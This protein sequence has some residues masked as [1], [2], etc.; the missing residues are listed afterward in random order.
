MTAKNLA[1][2]FGPTLMR[3]SDETKDMVVNHKIGC[4][5]FILNHMEIFDEPVPEIL[6]SARLPVRKNSLPSRR[7]APMGLHAPALPPRENA[8]F[9]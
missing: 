8:G 4:I 7:E 3:H 6:K 5:E 2:V 1:V 9:I